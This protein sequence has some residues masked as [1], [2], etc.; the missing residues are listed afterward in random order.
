MTCANLQAPSGFL[1]YVYVRTR[2]CPYTHVHIIHLCAR[3]HVHTY[4][5]TDAA[6]SAPMS[7]VTWAVASPKWLSNTCVYARTRVPAT[8]PA[9]AHT[10]LYT[11]TRLVVCTHAD[12]RA[13]AYACHTYVYACM[14]AYTYA[15]IRVLC[16]WL[17]GPSGR[18]GRAPQCA[19]VVL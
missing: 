18:V 3:L 5:R 15:H 11:H 13:R 7:L 12:T 16:G 4:F 17:V 2:T 10:C 14:H 19:M 8:A 6:W 9:Y 1:P